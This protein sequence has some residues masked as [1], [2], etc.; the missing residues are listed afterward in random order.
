MNL[1]GIETEGELIS[2]CFP[3][4]HSRIGRE[5]FEIAQI[6]SRFLKKMRENF[7]E[8]FF[9]EFDDMVD[10]DDDITLEMQRKASAWYYVAYG[11][12]NASNAAENTPEDP[13]QTQF[14][15]FPWL[16]DDVILK[17]TLGRVLEM[18]ES[19]GLV[20]SISESVFDEFEKERDT[21]LRDFQDRIHKKNRIWK[22][23]PEVKALAMFGSSATFLFRK[24]SDL[25][26]CILSSSDIE[27]HE[28]L[29]QKEQIAEL[30]RFL[31]TMRKLFKRAR[32]VESATV[33]VSVSTLSEKKERN[34]P[35][36]LPS[37]NKG[38]LR[39][40]VSCFKQLALI[41]LLFEIIVTPYPLYIS[42]VRGKGGKRGSTCHGVQL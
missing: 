16:V 5:K 37:E 31:P 13:P 39:E 42:V 29:G 38:C 32:I 35:V 3:K 19:G 28:E 20:S 33:P 41:L 36:V 18:Q 4:F 30:K 2:G 9:E 22:D 6:T 40:Y 27:N 7:R 25:D 26:L 10:D 15:S 34:D 23:M 17:I 1:Y 12:R 21:L 8:K 11:F 14:L 24:H